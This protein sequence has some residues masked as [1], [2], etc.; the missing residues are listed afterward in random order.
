MRR[1]IACSWAAISKNG[2]RT[3]AHSESLRKM[4]HSAVTISHPNRSPSLLGKILS[5]HVIRGSKN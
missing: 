1:R 5:V 3:R 4:E 2:A